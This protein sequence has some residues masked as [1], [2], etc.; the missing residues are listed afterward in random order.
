MLQKIGPECIVFSVR[1]QKFRYGSGFT[2]QL[3]AILHKITRGAVII[4]PLCPR[5]F[6]YISSN[7]AIRDR[8]Q[9]PLGI[10]VQTDSST[11]T[12]G[13][14]KRVEPYIVVLIFRGLVSVTNLLK[15]L[16][17]GQVSEP[18]VLVVE[19]GG[20]GEEGREDRHQG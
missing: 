19:V 17:S 3:L 13:F 16:G 8:F 18:P 1:L 2:T 15:G 7:I 5:R 12:P 9:P 11:L 6:L 4:A 14:Y 10:A 20:N